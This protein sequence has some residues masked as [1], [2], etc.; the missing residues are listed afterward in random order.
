MRL[1]EGFITHKMC[2]EHFTVSTDGTF[3]GIV[4]SNATAAFIVEC[5]QEETTEQEIIQK[6]MVKYN[7]PSDI[8]KEDVKKILDTLRGIKALDE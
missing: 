2:D 7:A 1:R 3:N 8:I 6:M 5:L 4:R